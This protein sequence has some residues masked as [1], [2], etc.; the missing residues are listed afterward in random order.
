MQALVLQTPFENLNMVH[1]ARLS[2]VRVGGRILNYEL[3]WS[4]EMMSIREANKVG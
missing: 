4:T 3:I 2:T 1:E